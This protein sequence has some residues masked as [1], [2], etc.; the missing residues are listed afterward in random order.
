MPETSLEEKIQMIP[1]PHK[2]FR[3]VETCGPQPQP[4]PQPEQQQQ[5]SESLIL[6]CANHFLTYLFI[7]FQIVALRNGEQEDKVII[8]HCDLSEQFSQMY[9]LG[10]KKSSTLYQKHFHQHKNR[11][12][13]NQL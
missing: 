2:R 13:I 8:S 10:K 5:K 12:N 7:V 3:N 1:V 11:Y 6:S 4:Q 9:Y